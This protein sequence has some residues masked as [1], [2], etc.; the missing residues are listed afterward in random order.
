MH[1]VLKSRKHIYSV[2][3]TLPQNERHRKSGTD[4]LRLAYTVVRRGRPGQRVKFSF[5]NEYDKAFLHIMDVENG[6]ITS[7]YA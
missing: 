5:P 4:K 3:S 6:R 2:F 7:P 1:D